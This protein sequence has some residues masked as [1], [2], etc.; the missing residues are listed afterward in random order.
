MRL[1]TGGEDLFTCTSTGSSVTS[2]LLRARY[3]VFTVSRSSPTW[4]TPDYTHV[5]VHVFSYPGGLMSTRSHIQVVSCPHCLMSTWSHVHVVSCP[6]CLV[7]TLS[8]VHVVSCPR[9]LIFTWSHVQ[10]SHFHVLSFQHCLQRTEH[11]SSV[12]YY[13]VFMRHR[14]LDQV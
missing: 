10:W 14:S 8:R 2:W 11:K 5:I 7:S 12:A 4:N 13:C 1:Q 9:G 6:R 3:V